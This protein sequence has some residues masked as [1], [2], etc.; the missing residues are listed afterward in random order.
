V[1]V[2]SGFTIG[3][4]RGIAIRVHWSWIAIFALLVW[5]LADGV[6]G[7]AFTGWSAGTRY[8]A[9]VFTAALFFGSVLLHELS[10]S[11]VALHYGMHVPS[12][13]LFIFGGVSSLGGEM[14]TPGQ[15]FRIAIAGPLMS[16]LLAL[17]FGGV[18]LL[19][20]SSEISTVFGY[21][22]FINALLGA[23]N[24]LPGF[25]LDGG[26]VFRSIVWAR[27]RNLMTATRVA[28][29]VGVFIAYLM[30]ALGAVTL[31]GFGQVGGLWYIVIGLFLK[32]ASEGSY[33]SMLVEAAL[34]N[35]SVSTVMRRPP[36][37][38][39]AVLSLQRL[40]DERVLT[41][42]ERAFLVQDGQRVV[43]MITT[44][45]L[46]KH[47][48]DEWNRT[49]VQQAMVP[50]DKVVTVRP[51]TELLEA[52]K[53][54]Q[55]H[56]IHQLPVIED[57]HVLGMVTRGDVIRQIE[58]RTEFQRPSDDSARLDGWSSGTG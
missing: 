3:T 4:V 48:R 8:A 11:F 57:G 47:P 2:N 29:Q 10:H 25:P 34:K 36:E 16:W 7:E 44:S 1:D 26:R 27:S 39:H 56:D 53:L 35:V 18:W 40:V 51:E 43:G 28:S 9:A 42:A 46:A 17:V 13:T 37:P 30:M 20:R 22:A 49:T 45:D 55:E 38:V 50:T 6:F 58:L 5:S 52:L 31:L 33:A 23:F 32:S 15:E 19:T 12:I 54:M 21:L 14:R 24:L 41:M